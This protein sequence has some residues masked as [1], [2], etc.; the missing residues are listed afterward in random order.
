MN[1]IILGLG[2]PGLGLAQASDCQPLAQLNLSFSS[3]LIETLI[4]DWIVFY[5]KNNEKLISMAMYYI[6]GWSK[7]DQP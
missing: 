5:F 6:L 1:W 2:Y 7:E 3:R 4:L